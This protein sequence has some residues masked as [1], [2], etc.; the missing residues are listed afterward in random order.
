M[1]IRKVSDPI[2]DKKN[3]PQSDDN[4]KTEVCS[5]DFKMPHLPA[6]HSTFL[7]STEEEAA[8][9]L[10]VSLNSCSARNLLGLNVGDESSA[11]SCLFAGT[12][13]VSLFS[14]S[15]PS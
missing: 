3:G 12:R 10:F 2:K 1:Q 15:G 11:D 7:G 13:S 8:L 6:D 9:W 14:A 5:E 4:P